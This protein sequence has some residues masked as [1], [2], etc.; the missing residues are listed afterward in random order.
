MHMRIT[1]DVQRNPD[2]VASLVRKLLPAKAKVAQLVKHAKAN[3]PGAPLVLVVCLSAGRCQALLKDL[4]VY[5]VRQSAAVCCVL[6]HV[7][8][9]V[10]LEYVVVVVCLA[11]RC[12][13][14]CLLE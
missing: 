1:G 4:T 6:L 10:G 2:S 7:C 3:P 8:P 12:L 13:T 5:V 9:C 14:S 11:S